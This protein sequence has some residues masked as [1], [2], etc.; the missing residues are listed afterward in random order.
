MTA[1]KEVPRHV[2][3]HGSISFDTLVASPKAGK[4]QNRRYHERKR[5]NVR[6]LHCVH[7]D[8]EKPVPGLSK[9]VNAASYEVMNNKPL[10]T[11]PL[12]VNLSSKFLDLDTLT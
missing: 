10:T 8:V 9:G 6:R 11:E 3:V 4:P 12:C 5:R 7:R 2:S 1:S